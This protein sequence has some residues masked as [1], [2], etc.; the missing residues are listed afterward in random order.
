MMLHVPG[1]MAYNGIFLQQ[2]W[3]LAGG[4]SVRFDE[5]QNT[6]R[7]LE[8]AEAV[9]VREL[10]DKIVVLAE[11]SETT[12]GSPVHKGLESLLAATVT[13]AWTAFET[14]AVDLWEAA[15]NERPR[16]GFLAL[17]I[18]P[19]PDDTPDEEGRK[20]RAKVWF[21]AWM[22][23]EP[24]FDI[25]TGMGTALVYM[26]NWDF[27]RRDDAATAYKKAFRD[28]TSV[29]EE[30]FKNKE[31]GWLAAARN[32]IVHNAGLADREFVKLVS[33]H[34]QWGLLEIGHRIPMDGEVV[35]TLAAS[36]FAQGK[37]LIA[38]VDKW[39]ADNPR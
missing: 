14:V 26:K 36:A 18:E 25:R 4:D 2:N 19:R 33:G 16:L 10:A 39:L 20:R 29:I 28:D 6:G 30:V 13:G 17:N 27:S 3:N 24:N 21:P 34:P 8:E 37:R 22:L 5:L 32:A 31:L 9:Q 1:H 7:E 35:G 12:R 15:L 23:L 11:S 38:F